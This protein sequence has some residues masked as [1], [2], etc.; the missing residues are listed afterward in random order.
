MN[1]SRLDP[2][3]DAELRR[4]HMLT[5]FGMVANSIVARYDALRGRDRRKAVRNPD[6]TAIAAPVMKAV[7]SSNTMMHPVKAPSTVQGLVSDTRE[8]LRERP[9][10]RRAFGIFRR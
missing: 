8:V 2:D 7:W 9:E 10:P 1:D 5:G 6:D 3:E 4:L